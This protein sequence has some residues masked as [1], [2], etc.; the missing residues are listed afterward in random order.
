MFFSCDAK[1]CWNRHNLR[2]RKSRENWDNSKCKKSDENDENSK[3][4]LMCWIVVFLDRVRFFDDEIFNWNIVIRCWRDCSSTWFLCINRR[5]HDKNNQ[6]LDVFIQLIFRS[7][8]RNREK[9]FNCLH[10]MNVFDYFF[11]N[12][13]VEKNS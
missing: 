4:I 13:V 9:N 11:Y 6:F 3:Q 2:R 12:F 8:C 5:M 10:Q 7:I 1:N